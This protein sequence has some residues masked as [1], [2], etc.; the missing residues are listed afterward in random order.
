MFT[1][2]A[3]SVEVLKPLVIGARSSSLESYTASAAGNNDPH[4]HYFNSHTGGKRRKHRAT[5]SKQYTAR[6]RAGG[7]GSTTQTGSNLA[8][9][10]NNNILERADSYETSEN[11][12]LV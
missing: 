4:D 10:A 6:T 3:H 12:F 5:D 9:K 2:R 11:N 7:L 1:E 8:E